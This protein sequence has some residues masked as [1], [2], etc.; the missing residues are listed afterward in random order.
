MLGVQENLRIYVGENIQDVEGFQSAGEIKWGFLWVRGPALPRRSGS[1][2]VLILELTSDTH[3]FHQVQERIPSE[4]K[5]HDAI[6]ESLYTLDLRSTDSD[7]SVV[8]S[9][10]MKLV[11]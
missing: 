7:T 10:A 4:I 11:F 3:C 9:Y 2:S 8:V 5:C 6:P 1:R